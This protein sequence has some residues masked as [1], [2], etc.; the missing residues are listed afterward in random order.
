MAV[1]GN[2]SHWYQSQLANI[3]DNSIIHVLNSLARLPLPH[4][5][6]SMNMIE[7]KEEREVR[8]KMGEEKRKMMNES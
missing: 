1:M 6:E 2:T 5:Q 8:I 3:I 7:E 4:H